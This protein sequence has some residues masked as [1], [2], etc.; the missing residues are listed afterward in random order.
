MVH[1]GVNVESH[2]LRHIR[3]LD[4]N[5]HFLSHHFF[6]SVDSS[7]FER[8]CIASPI[9]LVS[10]AL[11]HKRE[12]R[13]GVANCPRFNGGSPTR[14]DYWNNLLTPATRVCCQNCVGIVSCLIFAVLF[15]L[16]FWFNI[17][18][19][20]KSIVTLITTIFATR[21]VGPAMTNPM[22]NAQTRKAQIAFFH[23]FVAFSWFH[24]LELLTLP[25]FVLSICQRALCLRFELESLLATKLVLFVLSLEKFFLALSLVEPNCNLI[26]SCTC[27]IFLSHAL[28]TLILLYL[29]SYLCKYVNHLFLRSFSNFLTAMFYTDSEPMSIS[30]PNW[31]RT[32][33]HP[34]T[35]CENFTISKKSCG[36]MK[37]YACIFL[38]CAF[39]TNSSLPKS[40]SNVCQATWYIWPEYPMPS[41]AVLALPVT[42]I[43]KYCI[44]WLSD[45]PDPSTVARNCPD[46]S[47][48]SNGFPSNLFNSNLGKFIDTDAGGS[49]AGVETKGK[50]E[51]G[52]GVDEVAFTAPA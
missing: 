8:K 25:D 29:A 49:I 23:G 31:V 51:G 24:F 44:L 30:Y 26:F 39:T 47:G 7:N 22:A 10:N 41:I 4:F 45:A 6:C 52:P 11:V 21:S 18:A 2:R 48:H 37:E 38:N 14:K 16:L 36:L 5:S 40:C 32:L 43:F 46:H 12:C 34:D 15:P 13:S 3:S 27:A 28:N 35:T 42:N 1:W 33:T 9:Q 50:L 17:V 20:Q 19:V